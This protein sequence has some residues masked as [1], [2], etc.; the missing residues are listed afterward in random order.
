MAGNI[1][2]DTIIEN[3]GVVMAQGGSFVNLT[4]TVTSS[5]ASLVKSGAGFLHA[6]IVN[7]TAAGLVTI[8]DS[9]TLTGTKI[10]TLKASIVEGTYVYD[11]KFST[12][13]QVTSPNSANLTIVYR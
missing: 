6:V 4:S 11:V 12:G 3:G 13:L 1:L 8:W 9:T 5:A 7:S 10:G 2:E